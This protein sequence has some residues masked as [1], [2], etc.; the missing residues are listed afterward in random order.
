MC[1]VTQLCLTLCEPTDSSLPGLLCPWAFPEK[2][3]GVCWHFLLL[4]IFLTKG[5]N[6]C[7]LHL[8]HCKW[9]LYHWVI[10]EAYQAGVF[11]H[12]IL[13]FISCILLQVAISAS[14]FQ[15][16]LA[17][18]LS[19]LPWLQRKPWGRRMEK[20]TARVLVGHCQCAQSYLAVFHR[21]WQGHQKPVPQMP[22]H[23]VHHIPQMPGHLQKLSLHYFESAHKM[24]ISKTLHKSEVFHSKIYYYS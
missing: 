9:I 24:K 8:L 13:S 12:N 1:A 6:P 4:W 16:S 2:N 14:F 11:I 22:G 23:H 19:K 17:Q 15:A 10:R 3:T 5:L 7:L 20:C 21:M 18:G